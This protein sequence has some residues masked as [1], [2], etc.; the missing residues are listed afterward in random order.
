MVSHTVNCAVLLDRE[1]L[2]VDKIPCL[3]SK[4]SWHRAMTVQ[5]ID[6]YTRSLLLSLNMVIDIDLVQC[7]WIARSICAQ[8]QW[9][10]DGKSELEISLYWIGGWMIEHLFC[11]FVSVAV[12][13][14]YLFFLHA[15]VGV[16][17]DSYKRFNAIFPPFIKYRSKVSIF[18]FWLPKITPIMLDS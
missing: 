17:W 12:Y 9:S 1:S 6:S 16:T 15:P 18:A 8:V 4:S 10:S 3:D 5:R 13:I 14:F 11:T 7:R 2:T